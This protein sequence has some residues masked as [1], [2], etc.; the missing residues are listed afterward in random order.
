[1]IQAVTMVATMPPTMIAQIC[2]SL[3]RFFI[4]RFRLESSPFRW[5]RN[6]TLDYCFDAFSLREPVSTSLENA[7][8]RVHRTPDHGNALRARQI[9]HLPDRREA[10][11]SAIG[12]AFDHHGAATGAIGGRVGHGDPLHAFGDREIGRDIA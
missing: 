1:M 5:N 9:D 8:A 12:A 10:D 3:N 2:W 7:L 6:G 11:D 4:G